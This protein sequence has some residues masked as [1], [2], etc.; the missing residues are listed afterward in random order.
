MGCD[1]IEQINHIPCFAYSTKLEPFAAYTKLIKAENIITHDAGLEFGLTDESFHGHVHTGLLGRFNVDNLLACYAS[2]RAC[3]VAA[4]DA[5]HALYTVTPVAGRMERHGGDDKPTVVIDY[6]H[7]PGALQV[8]IEAVRVHC[9]GSLW[10]VFGCGGDRDRGKRAPMA[11]AAQAADH[12]ILTDDNP[13]TESSEAIIHDAMAGFDEPENV[14]VI[15]DR[16]AAIRYAVTTAVTG[17]LILIAGKGHENYQIVGTEKLHF[18]DRQQALA[19]LE[20]AS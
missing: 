3:D 2:L 20:L 15:Q 5:V 12:V 4:N 13:R 19:A 17:D 11:K 18:S 6:C 8:A 14:V 1:L 10:V 9:S 16:A 7:T